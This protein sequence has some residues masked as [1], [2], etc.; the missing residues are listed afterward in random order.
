MLKNF[1]TI[2]FRNFIRQRVF[3]LINILGLSVGL[4]SAILIF[5]YIYD[6]MSYDKMHPG[7]NYTY[8]LGAHFTFE[9]GNQ[10]TAT[11]TPAVWS[12]ELKQKFAGITDIT[13]YV[14]FG[15]PTSIN[16]RENDKILLTEELFWVDTAYADLIY[17]KL[18]QGDINTALDLP[19]N[20]L[21][22]EKEAQQ[23]FGD[24]DPLGKMLAIRHPWATGN[25]DLE[26][27]VSG[28]FYD[29]PSNSHIKPD[30]LVNM[31]ALKTSFGDQYDQLFNSWQ[32][33]WMSNYVRFREDADLAEARK[34][35]EEMIG[36]NLPESSTEIVPFFR[37]VRDIHFDAE[38]RWGNEDG[39]DVKYVFIFGS[40]AF[41]IMLIACINYMNLATA[42]S[43]KRSREVGIRK[44][45]G[46]NKRMLIFQFMSESFLT[47]LVSL[48][49]SMLLI[50]I[51]LPF[52]N[53]LAQKSFSFNHLLN[54]E[55][56]GIILGS[57]I[58]VSLVGGSYPAFFLSRY[59]PVDVLK[60]N[61]NSGKKGSE[62]LRKM[63][64]VAQFTISL[65]LIIC[66]IIILKQME[67]MQ[68]SKLNEAGKQMISIRFGG[69]A[70]VDRYHVFKNSLLQDPDIRE[71][72]LANHLPRQNYF[73]GIGANYRIPDINEE[74]F[75]WSELNVEF[76]FIRM[77]NLEIL[78]GRE[79]ISN[80]PADSNAYILNESAV[81]ELGKSNEEVIG[82][83]I[84]D[85][86]DEITGE[87]IGVV[88]DFPYRSMQQ[89]IGPL[90]ISG[91]PHPIDQIIYVKLPQGSIQEK[92]AVMEEKWK[93]IFPGIGFDYW[94]VNDEFGRMYESEAR[95]AD[96]T[97]SFSLLAI[98]I[99]C[100][101]LFGLASYMTEQR[102]K[103][104][105]I[106]KVMGA[107]FGQ[108]FW[109]FY[110][111]F[112]RMLFVAVIIAIPL[113]Y[114]LMYQ[115]LQEF[116]YRISIEWSYFGLAILGVFLLTILTVGYEL[117]KASSSNPAEALRYE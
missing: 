33:G 69:T 12:S 54:P 37:N 48:I 110:T 66:T 85:V 63:L 57:V 67:M 96:L 70:P 78:A 75:Q 88:R 10:F 99:A 89:A 9:N 30:Y 31:Q 3:T 95:M 25:T 116:A 114:L 106:R 64:V 105:G 4:A 104:I 14:W 24:D 93:E 35:L 15:Y 58:F 42:R 102:T 55:I 61:S 77:Y 97:K 108:I 91:R 45:M 11:N 84:E 40:I 87:I 82:H 98:F 112:T 76:N 113:G 46:T 52:F 107:S 13:R 21:I 73:G 72:T 22:S 103:E 27:I 56:I 44:T 41:L 65:L 86:S 92:L 53:S 2:T 34:F 60:G 1:I 111:V 68:N 8:R 47:T 101:G 5:I 71:I 49:F 62:L 18:K 94:F 32:G 115:W 83:R 59:R 79:F 100:L 16:Y 39:G 29:Y 117:I 74:E 38:Q 81:R 19:N 36:E 23:L 90:V 109:L 51:A 50:I 7:V 20:I 80:N 43:V 28:I 26:V 17:I 6:E